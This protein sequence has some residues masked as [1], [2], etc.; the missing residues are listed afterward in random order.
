MTIWVNPDQARVHSMEEA[1]G[2]LT[3]WVSSGPNWPMPW[4]GYM[5]TP[6]R[7]HSLRR[8]TWASCLKEGLRWLPVGESASWKSANSSFPSLQVTYPIGLNECEEPII[9]SLLES[10]ANGISLTGGK[11]IYLEIDIPQSLAEE[12]DQKVPPNWQALYHHNNQPP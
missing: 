2:N 8:G 5:R 12:P 1:V 6:A 7:H 4:C 10:L 11:S 9:T 3:A